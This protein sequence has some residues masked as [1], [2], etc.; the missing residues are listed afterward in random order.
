MNDS[1]ARKPALKRKLRKRLEEIVPDK[2][3]VVNKL[4]RENQIFYS[5]GAYNFKYIPS[6]ID[7][8]TKPYII[9]MSNIYRSSASTKNKP[10]NKEI[11]DNE[12]TFGILIEG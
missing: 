7:L 8:S 6:S 2:K 12:D 10:S 3:S 4:I 1:W 9:S 11:V 5:T